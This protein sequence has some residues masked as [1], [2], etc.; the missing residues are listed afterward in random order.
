MTHLSRML[1][2][3]EI[4]ENTT[5]YIDA[6]LGRNE[7]SYRVERNG[8]LVDAATGPKSD[9]LIEIAN[10]AAKTDAAQAVKK[11][12]VLRNETDNDVDEE[13]E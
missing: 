12:K 13:L 11:L 7:L 5:V 2:Q 4:D 10:G 3:G 8:G 9:I 6:A 1:I